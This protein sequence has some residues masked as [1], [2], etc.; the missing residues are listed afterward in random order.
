MHYNLYLTF[1]RLIMS[2]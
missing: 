2:P 1:F